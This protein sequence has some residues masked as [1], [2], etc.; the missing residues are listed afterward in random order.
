MLCWGLPS[1]KL[2]AS[3][4]LKIG[5]LTP[6]GKEKVFQPPIFRCKL[7]VSFRV[8]GMFL[9]FV[10]LVMIYFL[11]WDSSPFKN[12]RFGWTQ[13]PQSSEDATSELCRLSTKICDLG[14]VFLGLQKFGEMTF[15]P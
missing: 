9:G 8:P 5:R 7:A 11:P 3:L 12:P 6:I 2:T 15:D 14:R 1:L 10:E 13:S 4:P